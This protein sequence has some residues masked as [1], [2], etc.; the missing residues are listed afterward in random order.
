MHTSRLRAGAFRVA[1]MIGRDLRCMAAMQRRVWRARGGEWGVGGGCGRGYQRRMCAVWL[2]RE[3]GRQ[4]FGQVGR[5]LQLAESDDTCSSVYGNGFA[6]RI[7][8]RYAKRSYNAQSNGGVRDGCSAEYGDDGGGEAAQIA[9]ASRMA[10]VGLSR[11]AWGGGRPNPS[12]LSGLQGPGPHPWPENPPALE[13]WVEVSSGCYEGEPA[14]WRAR[15]SSGRAGLEAE[16]RVGAER[17]AC[18]DGSVVERRRGT[19]E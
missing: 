5:F 18:C 14:A 12:P 6:A 3:Q 7:G 2:A 13:N 1:A 4:S 9:L 8:D 11:C 10:V 15:E 17:T 19:N 16:R